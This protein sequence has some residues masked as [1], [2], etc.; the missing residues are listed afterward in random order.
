MTVE[1]NHT[2]EGVLYVVTE[3]S[4]Y[5]PDPGASQSVTM[6]LRKHEYTKEKQS[7]FHR[8]LLQLLGRNR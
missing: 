8:K 2:T 5:W 1:E 7:D 6:K 3:C 4:R